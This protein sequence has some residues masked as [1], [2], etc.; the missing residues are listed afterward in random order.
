MDHET[1]RHVLDL[2]GRVA[3]LSGIVSLLIWTLREQGAMSDDLETRLFRSASTAVSTLPPEME[4][5][6]DRLILALNNALLMRP[7]PARGEA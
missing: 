5:S 3:A 6:A 4:E 2:E 1:A 7:E